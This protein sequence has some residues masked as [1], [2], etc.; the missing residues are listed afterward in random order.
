MGWLPGEPGGRAV[1]GGARGEPEGTPEREGDSS[2]NHLLSSG[3]QA[4]KLNVSVFEHL[5]QLSILLSSLRQSTLCLQAKRALAAALLPVQACRRR[6]S[7]RRPIRGAPTGYTPR[8][9][10]GRRKRSAQN[11]LPCSKYSKDNR[12]ATGDWNQS[13][14]LE[15]PEQTPRTMEPEPEPTQQHSPPPPRTRRMMATMLT[16]LHNL[17]LSWTWPPTR[18]R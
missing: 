9:L 13:C 16:R 4:A 15:E 3:G 17:H 6:E 10:R 7:E 12:D 18:T 8:T 5:R 1:G 14:S 2:S 11:T